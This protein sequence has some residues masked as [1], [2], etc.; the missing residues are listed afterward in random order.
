VTRSNLPDDHPLTLPHIAAGDEIDPCSLTGPAAF[1][2]HGNARMPGRQTLDSCRVPV[3]T[4]EGPVEVWVGDRLTTKMLGKDLTNVAELGRGARIV[5]FQNRCET[6]Y[7][8]LRTGDVVAAAANEASPTDDISDELLCALTQGA[9]QGVFNVLAGGRVEFW[10]PAKDS[11]ASVSACDV[12]STKQVADALDIPDKAPTVPPAHHWC[13]WGDAGG[14]WAAI[15]FSVAESVED[16]GVPGGTPVEVIGG[17]DSY[18]VDET[19]SCT[20]YTQHKEFEQ[21]NDMFEFAVLSVSTT[22]EPCVTV[23]ALAGEAWPEL[24]R[25]N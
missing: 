22:D 2:K 6:A 23:R 16:V 1:E 21:G 10:T 4:A 19:T 9:A 5:R 3:S 15:R 20:A 8:V 14:D 25:V 13:E 18:V 7:L 17:R 24:P 12:L 11:L